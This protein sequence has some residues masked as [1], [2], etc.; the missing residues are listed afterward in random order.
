MSRIRISKGMSFPAIVASALA[1]PY[2]Q[3]FRV[4]SGKAYRLLDHADTVI[5]HQTPIQQDRRK[6]FIIHPHH[7][8]SGDQGAGRWG[9]G[10]AGLGERKRP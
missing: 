3:K 6:V 5:K 10:L 8:I 9:S 7:L 2:R 4:F 1:A